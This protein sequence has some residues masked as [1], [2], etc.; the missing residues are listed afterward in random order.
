MDLPQL[1]ISTLLSISNS[2]T[3][4]EQ[5]T[6]VYHFSPS[7]SQEQACL[8]AEN[9][10]KSMILQ[11]TVG[12]SIHAN[13]KSNCLETSNEVSCN[14]DSTSNHYTNGQISKV[15]F[16]KAHVEEWKCT[17]FLRAEVVKN[18]NYT[19]PNF[20]LNIHLNTK[21][22]NSGDKVDFNFTPTKP[23][24]IYVFHYNKNDNTVKKVYPTSK[25][26][27]TFFYENENVSSNFLGVNYK[28]HAEDDE[29][30]HYL[31]FIQYERNLSLLDEYPLNYFHK[32]FDNLD[33][34]KQLYKKPVIVL[35]R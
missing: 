1:A 10:A 25:S 19:D 23:S 22:Y 29:E 13:V 8:K 3:L 31:F 35:R 4:V 15:I 20:N 5:A 2:P 9:I 28:L 17:V 30:T 12:Q 24:H 32:I 26:P 33:M 6:G 16:K 14:I 27:N 21:K 18:T 11:K 7:V 34:K